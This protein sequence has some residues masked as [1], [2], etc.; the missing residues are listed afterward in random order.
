MAMARRLG[1]GRLLRRWLVGWKADFCCV[2]GD[3]WWAGEQM[4]AAA[5]AGEIGSGRRLRSWRWLVGWSADGCG[6]DGW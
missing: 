5:M 1:G 2:D 4:A 3:G 6:G